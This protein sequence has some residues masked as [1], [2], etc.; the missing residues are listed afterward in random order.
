M[1]VSNESA[2][3]FFSETQQECEVALS[4]GLPLHVLVAAVL[5]QNRLLLF[6]TVSICLD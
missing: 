4:E 3:L 1:H 2:S 5:T 6:Y